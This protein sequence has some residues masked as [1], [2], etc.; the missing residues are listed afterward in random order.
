MS[1]GEGST[2]GG[3]YRLLSQIGRGGMG[4]V[5]HAHDELLDR[6]VAAK[7]MILPSDFTPAEYDEVNQR[8]LKEARLAGRLSHPAIVKIYDVVEE[9]GRPWIVM[10]LIHAPSLRDL[11][12]ENG[13]LE[14]LLVAKIGLQV[15]NGLLV[16]HEAGI[17]HRD[18]KPG[19]VLVDESRSVRAVLTDFGIAR[20]HSDA[21]TLNSDVL[22]GS[23]AY[24]APERV[25]GQLAAAASDLWSLGATLY[26]AAEGR[27]A[28]NKPEAVAS[29]VAVLNDDPAP[30][31]K[32]GPLQ[33]VID[34]LLCK[35]PDERLTAAEVVAMLEQVT[36]DPS[37]TPAE[38]SELLESSAPVAAE[39]SVK[40]P[41]RRPTLRSALLVATVVAVIADLI[42]FTIVR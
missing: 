30:I 25:G 4:T 14:P 15:A 2:L 5:W 24:M 40:S 36:N 35:N 17:L 18:V 29:L 23:A 11:I 28:F 9:E 26:E 20:A 16:A 33:P 38:L 37:V 10:E 7:A 13:P 39:P 12:D 27:P 32:A 3:R 19:N 22:T 8:T 41:R 6:E 21:T 42:I 34:G 31:E 1:L